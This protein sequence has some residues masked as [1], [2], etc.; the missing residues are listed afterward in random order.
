MF[1]N[2]VVVGCL[3]PGGAAEFVYR[4]GSDIWVLNPKPQTLNPKP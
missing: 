1:K 3:I 4:R 2:V